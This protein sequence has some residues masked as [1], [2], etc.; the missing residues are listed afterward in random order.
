MKSWLLTLSFIA[1]LNCVAC[2]VQTEPE[3]TD[4]EPGTITPYTE[5]IRISWDYT[6]LTKVF[7]GGV[8]Y[9]RMMRLQDNRLLASFESAGASWVAF[10]EDEGQSW[11]NHALVA[12][13]V[14]GISAAVPELIQLENGNIILAYNTRPPQNN[15]DPEKNFGIK[16]RIS[17]D[18]G[19]SWSEEINVYEGGYEWNRG[20][21]EPC[22]IQ[23]EDG[24]IQLYFA[25][26]H[27]YENSH[28]QEISMATSSDGGRT[29]SEPKT[30]SYR[31]GFRDGMPVPVQLQ[32]GGTAVAIEDNGLYGTTFKPAIIYTEGEHWPEEYA[33]AN[34]SRRWGALTEDTQLKG[35]K[36]GGAPY[37]VQLP[38]G[39]TILS[40]QGNDNRPGEWDRSSMVVAV[41]DEFAK[42]FNRL[43]EPFEVPYDR[44]AMWNSLF[45]KNDTT[46]TAVASTSAYSNNG[47][48][49]FY[50][51][52]GYVQPEMTAISSTITVDG[53]LTSTEW[54]DAPSLFVGARG[55]EAIRL[56][57]AQD[58]N[59]F[60]VSIRQ[61]GTHVLSSQQS[62]T[63]SFFL[64]TQ[65]LTSNHP[66]TGT[67][68]VDISSPET[69]TLFEWKEDNWTETEGIAAFACSIDA[70]EISLDKI[71]FSSDF[72][73]PGWGITAGFYIR[74]GG[75]AR[76]EYL[77]G[78]D[79][80]NPVTWLKLNME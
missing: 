73:L 36:Y 35:H 47:G 18:L 16:L 46:V 2:A 71:L 6:T 42:N 67:F 25:N 74:S 21:W 40:F 56:K 29:W 27:P 37:L 11:I 77:S 53:T 57:A 38:S 76:Q 51:I 9:P 24:T 31:S 7:E 10:S 79:I 8:S 15:V 17:E 62:N 61:E 80:N 5:G 4:P 78:T 20:V 3:K 44:A 52:D 65:L 32:N 43:S 68:R 64:V 26:E 75:S 55:E 58:E 54:A 39:Q 1:L 14:D 34:S 69:A 28:D 23:L 33:D 49:E 19:V 30:I 22:M 12:P 59:Y 63:V 70:C 72:T 41:G 45:V 60:S 50:A 66:G 48:A 13:R